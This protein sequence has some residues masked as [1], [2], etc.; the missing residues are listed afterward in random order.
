MA[1]AQNDVDMV[2][3][4]GAACNDNTLDSLK[5]GELTRGE[6]QRNAM[7]IL[8]FLTTTHAMK[9]VMGC[10]DE[11]EIINRPADAGDVDS[12]DIEFHDIDEDLTLDLTGITTEKGSSYA[13][14]LNVSKPGVYKVTL[15]ALQHS[16]RACADFRVHIRAGKPL[17]YVHVQWDRRSS[18]FPDKGREMPV[19]LHADTPV[20][21]RKRA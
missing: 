20:F 8:R 5:S 6:L 1:M 19:K 16:F 3:A 12:T 2:T 9:R 14:G 18:G 7:N 21:R 11:T 10:D 13:F 4:D 15:T 17:R